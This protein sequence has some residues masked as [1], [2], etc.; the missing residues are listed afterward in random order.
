MTAL[1]EMFVTL[2]RNM[3]IVSIYTMFSADMITV[4]NTGQSYNV[5]TVDTLPVI[6]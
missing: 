3:D 6:T 5:G 1:A 2:K 4:V